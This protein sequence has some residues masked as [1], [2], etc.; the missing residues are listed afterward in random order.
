LADQH[1]LVAGGGRYRALLEIIYFW[2]SGGDLRTGIGW[3]LIFIG[4]NLFQIY[5]LVKDRLFQRLIL[6]GQYRAIGNVT[7]LTGREKPRD[8]CIV[9]AGENTAKQC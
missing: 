4:I 3:D 9:E 1:V 8:L 6:F 5:Q 2:L 7:K